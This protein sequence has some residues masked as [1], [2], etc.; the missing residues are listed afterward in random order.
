MNAAVVADAAEVMGAAWFLVPV[1]AAFVD[2]DVVLV[3]V[4]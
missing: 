3:A 1:A 4:V 2:E